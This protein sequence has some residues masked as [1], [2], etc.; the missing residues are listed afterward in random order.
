MSH[1][2]EQKVRSAASIVDAGSKHK[3]W[4]GTA[5]P[6][7]KT[8]ISERITRLHLRLG[9]AAKSGSGHLAIKQEPCYALLYTERLLEV[10]RVG[11]QAEAICRLAWTC[12]R[13]RA[14]C[15]RKLGLCA[16]AWEDRD[17]LCHKTDCSRSVSLLSPTSPKMINPK[18]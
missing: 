13:L 17:S 7:C 11:C 4:A 1:H 14:V 3:G 6:V 5:Q 9:V 12:L 10:W 15:K 18:P 16:S 2:S 8:V